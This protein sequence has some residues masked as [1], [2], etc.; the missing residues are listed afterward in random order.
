[1]I[2]INTATAD[3]LRELIAQ[4]ATRLAQL[5]QAA[6]ITKVSGTLD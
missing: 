3:E 5:E 1:M 2:D 6:T 4:A